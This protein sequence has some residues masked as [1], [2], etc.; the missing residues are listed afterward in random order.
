MKKGLPLWA[1]DVGFNLG[2]EHRLEKGGFFPDAFQRQGLGRSVPI[3]GNQGS[4]HTDEGFGE[5][6]IPL[7]RHDNHVPLVYSLEADGKARYVRNTVN[8]GFWAYTYGGRYAPVRDVQFRGN[9]TRSL[10][11]PS[12]TELFTP[13]SPAFNTFPDPCDVANISA[14][15]APAVR[16]RNCAAFFQSYGVNGSTF[17]SLARVATVPITSGGNTSLKNEEGRS[18]TFGMVLQPR[19]LRRF[20]ASVDWNRIFIKGNIA[21]LTPANIAEGCYDNPSFDASDVDNANPF[22]SLIQRDRSSDAARN[23]QLSLD[24]ARPAIV[25]T[26][27]NGAFIRQKNLTAEAEYSV[28]LSGIGVE[29]ARLDLSGTFFYLYSYKTSNNGVTVTNMKG[30]LANPIY[31]GQLNVGLTYRRIGI[32]LQANYQGPQVFDRTFTAETRDIFGVGHYWLYN[33]STSLK[34]ADNSQIRFVISNLFDKDPPFPLTTN[35][36]G[37]Y[38]YLGRRF[39]VSFNLKI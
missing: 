34:V 6:T 27:V 35:G 7:V 30:T 12:I 15:V 4:F 5:V 9:Y 14:G 16:A 19:F 17:N 20:R 3:G 28:P 29:E 39:A 21:S 22:C 31:S 11:A 13:A 25:G 26:F 24:P 36:L 2:Y 1:G 37:V 18:Y 10:R 38:D 32:D 8:G 33:L 23:G